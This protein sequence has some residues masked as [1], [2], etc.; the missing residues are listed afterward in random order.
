[1][2][3]ED[4]LQWL[5]TSAFIT[6]YSLMSFWPELRPWPLVFGFLGSC[7]FMAWCRLVRNR[8][9]MIVNLVGAVISLMGV[10]KYLSA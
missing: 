2:H 3:K 5:G 7:L 6:M 1:M 9:Q 4:Q 8:P 10:I